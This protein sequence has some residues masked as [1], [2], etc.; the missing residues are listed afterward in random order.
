MLGSLARHGDS[1]VDQGKLY[2]PGRKGALPVRLQQAYS[3]S[4]LGVH[5]R[6]HL[7]E[8]WQVALRKGTKSTI[9]VAAVQRG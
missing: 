9:Q 6:C 4:G 3:G 5:G 8:V 2:G 7:M 1:G